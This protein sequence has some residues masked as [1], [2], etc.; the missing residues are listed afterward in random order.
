MSLSLLLTSGLSQTETNNTITLPSD[1]VRALFESAQLYDVC[2]TQLALCD[3]F[4]VELKTSLAT[5]DSI[6]VLLNERIQTCE[7]LKVKPAIINEHSLWAKSLYT[8]LG[9]T[10]VIAIQR[11]DD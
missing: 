2:N 8:L 7:D 11:S 6:I 3:S 1:Q 5:K 9:A 10:I 4:V